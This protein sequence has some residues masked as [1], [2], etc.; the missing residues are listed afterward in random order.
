MSWISLSLLLALAFV[1]PGAC[2]MVN[3]TID[4]QNGDQVTGKVP[5]YTPA[6]GWTQGSHC[7]GCG[8]NISIG[9]DP[10]ELFD[11]TWH[12]TTV[13]PN[14]PPHA[15]TMNFT[16]SAVYVFNMIANHVAHVSTATHLIF[17]IDGQ[18]VGTYD[19]IPDNTSAFYYHVPVYTNSSLPYGEH[20]LQIVADG[21]QLSLVLFDYVVCVVKDRSYVVQP[22]LHIFFNLPAPYNWHLDT[23]KFFNIIVPFNKHLGTFCTIPIP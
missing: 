1:R 3:R 17:S 14:G 12:D 4:D 6:G 9:V 22:H 20:D 5:I 19:H 2:G 15:I 13:H 8:I 18:R 16:G 10:G 21:S 23:F 7:N 11:G